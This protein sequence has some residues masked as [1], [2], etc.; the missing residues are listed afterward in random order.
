MTDIMYLHFR[1]F[2]VF[3]FKKNYEWNKNLSIQTINK[4]FTT[5]P[6]RCDHRCIV[7]L[8]CT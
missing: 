8:P 1:I 3:R 4:C 5:G 7:L 2:Y 6:Y